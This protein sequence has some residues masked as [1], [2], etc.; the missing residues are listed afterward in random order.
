M[1][2]P[3][4]KLNATQRLHHPKLRGRISATSNSRHQ[5]G[6]RQ[7]AERGALDLTRSVHLARCVPKLPNALATRVVQRI[8]EER[9]FQS[10]RT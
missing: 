5:L 4:R 7:P 1:P 9:R 10:S 2:A 3:A 8:M 6:A